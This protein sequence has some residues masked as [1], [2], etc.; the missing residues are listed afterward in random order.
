MD[1]SKPQPGFNQQQPIGTQMA[2]NQMM[3][4]QQTFQLDPTATL[5]RLNQIRMLE[6]SFGGRRGVAER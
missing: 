3:P 1:Y 4:G 6:S 5:A 2:G